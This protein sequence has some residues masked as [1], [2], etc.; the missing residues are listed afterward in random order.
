M[1]N[2][3][4]AAVLA[5][6]LMASGA[7]AQ[8][9]D[10]QLGHIDRVAAKQAAAVKAPKPVFA[11]VIACGQPDK[12]S[13]LP[14]GLRFYTRLES[15]QSID[16]LPADDKHA[17]T[18]MWQ[19]KPEKDETAGQLNDYRAAR[20]SQEAFRYDTWSCDT[21][22]FYFAFPTEGLLRQSPGQLSRPIKARVLIEE[23]GSVDYKGELV[24]TAFFQ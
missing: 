16:K 21:E 4:A 15:V 12:K 17:L 20:V 23:R 2:L 7:N 5:S 1:T 22:D 6:C 19:G 8:S 14:D 9:F 11:K 10:R 24:C 18:V 13:G 3:S